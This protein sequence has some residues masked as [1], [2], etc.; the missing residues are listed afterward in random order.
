MN[1][2]HIDTKIMRGLL[3]MIEKSKNSIKI[4]RGLLGDID[5]KFIDQCSTD[6]GHVVYSKYNIT[7]I[8]TLNYENHISFH[9]NKYGGPYASDAILYNL[10]I[11][12]VG[13]EEDGTTWRYCI[14]L[15]DPECASK[16]RDI[17]LKAIEVI[18]GKEDWWEK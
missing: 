14:R 5:W 4:I 13:G 18:G 9:I 10:L 6:Y 1:N 11:C 16:V 15:S 7:L 12:R 17:A 3:K 8:V 2:H